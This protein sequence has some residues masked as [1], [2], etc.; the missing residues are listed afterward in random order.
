M[1]TLTA[2]DLARHAEATRTL[3]SPF[4]YRDSDAWRAAVCESVRAF[5]GGDAVMAGLPGEG[6][7]LFSPHLPSEVLDGARRFLEG[8]TLGQAGSPDPRVNTFYRALVQQGIDAVDFDDIDR[9]TGGGL[10]DSP[11]Y[12]EV[13][14]PA[15]LHD[16]RTLYVPAR[17]VG[18]NTLAALALYSGRV[19]PRREGALRFQRLRMLRPALEAGVDTVGRLQGLREAVDTVP[20]PLIA[21][22]SDGRVLHRTPALEWL[23]RDDPRRSEIETV[24]AAL[25]RRV[26]AYTSAR[27]SR[28]ADGAAALAR[29]SVATARGRYDL[30]ATLLPEGL[31][32]SGGAVLVTAERA[33]RAALPSVATLRE[34]YGLSPREAEV[35]ILLAEGLP[36]DA[37]ALRLAISPHTARRHTESV[38]RKLLVESRAGVGARLF[39]ND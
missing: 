19:V 21:F 12:I 11:A 6:S 1:L 26:A 36:N 33:G 34:Q 17:A 23:L 18:R 15:G 25:A 39:R 32:G 29:H 31:S 16:M 8:P 9:L 13:F 27:R 24:A 35:A 3:L 30:R 4:A 10:Y 20:V 38:M 5:V 2:E 7:Y 37:L 22:G 28:F 14:G